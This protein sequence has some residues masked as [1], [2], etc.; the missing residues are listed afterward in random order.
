MTRLTIGYMPDLVATFAEQSGLVLNGLGPNS[1]SPAFK[2]AI[3]GALGDTNG[4]KHGENLH[5]LGYKHINIY[6]QYILCIYICILYIYTRIHVLHKYPPFRM[7]PLVNEKMSFQGLGVPS[8][9][10]G[11][12]AVRS[13]VRLAA[14]P[15]SS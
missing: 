6:V 8:A 9:K 7:N 12:D 11:W 3:G 14:G 5:K 4:H 13:L 1:L 2:P 10:P 15:P